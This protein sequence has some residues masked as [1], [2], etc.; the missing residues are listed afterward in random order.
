MI[1]KGMDNEKKVLKNLF[2]KANIRIDEIKTR[3]KHH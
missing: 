3:K 2:D 1:D